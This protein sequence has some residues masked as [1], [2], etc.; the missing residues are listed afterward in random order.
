[1]IPCYKEKNLAITLQTVEISPVPWIPLLSH[2]FETKYIDST[3]T[4][5]SMPETICEKALVL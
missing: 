5:I 1:M 3:A 4:N 2:V